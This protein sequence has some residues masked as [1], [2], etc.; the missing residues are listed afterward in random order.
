MSY[1]FP[2]IVEQT[3][4]ETKTKRSTFLHKEGEGFWWNYCDLSLPLGTE[5]KRCSDKMFP[6]LTDAKIDLFNT[7]G[8]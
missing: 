3:F 7:H 5:Y 4:D 2:V 8:V 6:T 1:A